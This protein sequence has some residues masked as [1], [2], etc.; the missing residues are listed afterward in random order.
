[1]PVIKGTDLDIS[2]LT[3]SDVKVDNH[4]RKMIF[5]NYDGGKLVIQTP[6]MY[7]PNGIKRWRKKDAVDNKDDS[8]EIEMTF[9][10]ENTNEDLKNFHIKM[11]SIDK[12]IKEQIMSHSKEW[13]GKQKVSME[14]IE[15]AFYAPI[16]KVPVDKEGNVLD[17]PSRIKVKLDRERQGDEFTG[18]FLAY[19]KPPSSIMIFDSKKNQLD[20]SE[21]NFES[22]ISKGSHLTGVLELV[23]LT[24]TTKISAKWKLIQGKVYNNSKNITSYAMIDSD[25]EGEENEEQDEREERSENNIENVTEN[26]VDIENGQVSIKEESK[27]MWA[28]EEVQP[29]IV[30]FSDLTINDNNISSSKKE[31]KKT[32]RKSTKNI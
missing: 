25:T 21:D 7:T 3:F 15:D 4:G 29:D 9:S 30:D 13:L 11:K 32:G 18:R 24:I 27:Q 16:V 19:K 14:V 31:P 23:Y 26:N 2:K 20:I 10:G 22:V 8:F 17:Y 1:M 12:L 5:V 28:D 6:K